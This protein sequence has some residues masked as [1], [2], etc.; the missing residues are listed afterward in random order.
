L[1]TDLDYELNQS[2]VNA[3]VNSVF[4]GGGTPS[5]FS[6]HSMAKL[7]VGLEDRLDLAPDIEITMEANPGTTEY[8]DFAGYKQA[9]INR[10]SIGVQSFSDKQLNTLGR[11]HNSNE[12]RLAF[13]NARKGGFRNINLD[14]MFAL[15]NQSMQDAITDISTAIDL[16][17][18]H[19]SAYQL[20]LEPDTV[21][22][23]YPPKL[24]SSDHAWEIESAIQNQ[25]QESGYN[26]YEISAY[27]LP[28]K[29]CKHNLNYWNY[30]DYIGIGA[31]A[32]GKRTINHKITRLSRK[33]HPTTFIDLAGSP[34]SIAESKEVLEKE[35]LFEFLMNGL[36]LTDG[37]SLDYASKQTGR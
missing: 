15:P 27:S 5:L 37:V 33:K 4:M 11:V 7:L 23:R 2:P 31:G 30:G 19:I 29:Q 36:R 26:R 17:P 3:S 10:L 14:L 28:D 18:E 9:G 20:T 24:P 1:L 8:A 35:I 32:H 25:L 16:A 34:G 13:S 12:A 22:Y 6:P 21:F